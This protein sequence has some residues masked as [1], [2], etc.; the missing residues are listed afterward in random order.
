MRV[1]VLW[2]VT[3]I[4]M[5]LENGVDKNSIMLKTYEFMKRR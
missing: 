5:L 3:T 4:A 2:K 1:L